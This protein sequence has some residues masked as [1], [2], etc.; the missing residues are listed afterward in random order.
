MSI[1]EHTE[2]TNEVSFLEVASEIQNL[3]Q[4]L[5][6]TSL[7]HQ[8][9]LVGK[10]IGDYFL[11]EINIFSIDSSNIDIREETDSD[12][13]RSFVLID[14]EEL[15]MLFDDIIDLMPSIDKLSEDC[16]TDIR[17]HA[18]RALHLMVEQVKGSIG[19][20]RIGLDLN[21]ESGLITFNR[22]TAFID[23]ILSDGFSVIEEHKIFHSIEE[24][25]VEEIEP[26]ET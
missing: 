22:W 12:L 24:P 20:L 8:I 16:F 15:D 19:N 18:L 1:S 5:R 21:F 14:G 9:M 26:L 25:V 4:L 17:G 11:F 3:N 13:N 2:R 6:D 10:W 23:S 7:E